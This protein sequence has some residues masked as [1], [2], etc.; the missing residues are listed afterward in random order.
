MAKDN[1]NRQPVDSNEQGCASKT[2]R[3]ADN[4]P[5]EEVTGTISFRIAVFYDGTGNNKLNTYA[6]KVVQSEGKAMNTEKELK[7]YNEK[8]QEVVNAYDYLENPA[9]INIKIAKAIE[10]FRRNRSEFEHEK[11]K[12][13]SYM[14]ADT[15]V[16]KMFRDLIKYEPQNENPNDTNWIVF[17]KFYTEGMGTTGGE[18]DDLLGSAFG[19]G[20]SGIVGRS[21]KAKNIV[22][23]FIL[24]KIKEFEVA[25]QKKGKHLRRIEIREIDFDFYGFSRGSAT[26]RYS[27]KS[28]LENITKNIRNHEE[29]INVHL[30][31]N[32]SVKQ[33]L[34]DKF[35][36]SRSPIEY[37]IINCNPK[38]KN[39]GIFDTVA[40]FGIHG[41]GLQQS[42]V[43]ELHLKSVRKA[44][45]IFHI[46]AG[47]EFRVNFSLTTIGSAVKVPLSMSNYQISIPGA[48]CDI[49][50]GYETD[51]SE[52]KPVIHD[53]DYQTAEKLAFWF[54][55]QGYVDRILKQIGTDQYIEV[56]EKPI[57]QSE[58][59]FEL[60]EPINLFVIKIMYQMGLDLWDVYIN[61]PKIYN[62]YSR[63]PLCFMRDKFKGEFTFKTDNEDSQ[64][65]A[66]LE[67]I[68]KS[69][70]TENIEEIKKI[71]KEYIH[72]SGHDWRIKG[73]KAYTQRWLLNNSGNPFKRNMHDG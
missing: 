42:N 43:E 27:C 38:I 26:A 51:E 33:S 41:T 2:R 67:K 62:S 63:I 16:Y 28:F 3:N 44:E 1:F 56:S 64:L 40:S 24:K 59:G 72:F 21:D 58:Y 49:G 4:Q 29:K 5:L 14:G 23:Q 12:P 65:D 37:N 70:E 55:R 36:L 53:V 52:D 6:R 39:V 66:N 9:D 22:V 71:R 50:G 35:L 47:D 8:L 31:V 15:N 69:I 20:L 25:I 60:K 57:I 17:K 68:K 48:H 34:L 54:K 18:E 61:R 46:T 11:K 19:A 73:F 10:T 30:I 45:K 7:E 32:S 13:V